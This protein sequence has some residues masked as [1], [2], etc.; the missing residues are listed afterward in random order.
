MIF[1]M[2][3]V[4][5]FKIFVLLLVVL[6]MPVF[7][8]VAAP[9]KKVIVPEPKNYLAITDTVAL[10]QKPLNLP[11]LMPMA[12]I[13]AQGHLVVANRN[14][15]IFNAYPLPITGSGISGVHSGRGPG[16]LIAY[17]LMSFAG[18]DSGFYVADLDNY[19]KK[20]TISGGIISQTAKE[21]FYN[22][23]DPLNGMIKIKGKFLN[24][25]Y[26]GRKE[27]PYEF[28]V[29]NPDG[30]KD[31]IGKV[32]DWNKSISDGDVTSIIE[33]MNCHIAQ[34]GGNRIAVFYCNYR[35]VRIMNL[36]GQL[37]SETS[38]N[39]PTNSSKIPDPKGTYRMYGSACASN[40]RMVVRV[41]N[42]VLSQG[43]SL[44]DRKSTEFQIWDWEGH[45]LKRMIVKGKIDVFTVDYNTNTFYGLDR[46]EDSL[47]YMADISKLL[48]G[49]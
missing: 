4:I 46:D 2:Y 22:N 9:P 17:D 27:H 38:I 39:Y 13:V 6:S 48:N 42:S 15:I 28:V 47:L 20:F 12:M 10:V 43:G 16:E 33:Y 19:Y 11:S 23:N 34:P 36:K 21:R 3:S 30:S 41:Y 25:N 24:C 44:S 1:N 8:S 35:K 37:L 45:L 7:N 31:Y 40:T 49:K 14:A 29:L 26:N 18:D 5:R 32:P